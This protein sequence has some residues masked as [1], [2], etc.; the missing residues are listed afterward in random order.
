MSRIDAFRWAEVS[1]F[2][3]AIDNADFNFEK[4]QNDLL[5]FSQLLFLADPDL[6]FVTCDTGFEGRLKSSAQK[7]RIIVCQRNFADL[8]QKLIQFSPPN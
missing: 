8:T 1:F 2:Q 5:D 3:A 6:V 7:D 4:Y